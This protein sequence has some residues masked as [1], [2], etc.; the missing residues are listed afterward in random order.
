MHSSLFLKSQTPS[1]P[2]KRPLD[3]NAVVKAE[4]S[5]ASSASSAG[6]ASKKPKTE[7][8]KSEGEKEDNSSVVSK[9]VVDLVNTV[10]GGGSGESNGLKSDE[11]R[12]GRLEA[13]RAFRER[14]LR[15][16]LRQN[17]NKGRYLNDVCNEGGRLKN[18]D[19]WFVD[20]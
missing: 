4:S 15:R 6:E 20:S 14:S 13:A 5:T 3:S 16:I 2:R 1:S 17:L 12:R 8:D 11:D 7:P 19:I 9:V 10:G 18:L